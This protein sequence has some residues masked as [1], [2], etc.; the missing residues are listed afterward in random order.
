MFP[1]VWCQ[2]GVC[3]P[4]QTDMARALAV[5]LAPALHPPSPPVSLAP[6]LHPLS[7]SS[8]TPQPSSTEHCSGAPSSVTRFHPLE[9]LYPCGKWAHLVTHR[10]DDGLMVHLLEQPYLEV[11]KCKAGGEREHFLLFG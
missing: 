4:S 2:G 10:E 9:G 3:L 11:N 7:P 5:S 6:A 8:H 1:C